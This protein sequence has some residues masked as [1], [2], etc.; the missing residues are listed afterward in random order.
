MVTRLLQALCRSVSRRNHGRQRRTAALRKRSFR[1]LSCEHLEDRRILNA[2]SLLAPGRVSLDLHGDVLV[3]GWT[4]SEDFPAQNAYDTTHNGGSDFVVTKITGLASAVLEAGPDATVEEGTVFEIG[5]TLVDLSG[6]SWT[7]WADFGDESGL[8]RVRLQDDGTFQVGH[9]FEDNGQYTVTVTAATDGDHVYAD[10]DPSGTL[11]DRYP[12]RVTVTDDD[13]GVTSGS[14]TV[15]VVNVVPALVAVWAP[16]LVDLREEFE[17]VGYFTDPSPTDV[18]TCEVTW[19]DG[20]VETVEFPA[21]TRQFAFPHRYASGTWRGSDTEAYPITVTLTDDDGGLA[22]DSLEVAVRGPDIVGNHPLAHPPGWDFLD[23]EGDIVRPVF[24]GPD[25]Y[26]ELYFDDDH[27]LVSIELHETALT[28][29]LAFHVKQTD[30]GDGR[31]DVGQITSDS[32][33]G[34]LRLGDVNLVGLGLNASAAIERV[35]LGNVA[36]DVQLAVQADVAD[37]LSL[38]ADAIGTNVTLDFGGKLRSLDVSS[39]AGGE[40]HVADAETIDVRA[41]DFG[42]D[43]WIDPALNPAGGFRSITVVGGD[44]RGSIDVPGHG[45]TITVRAQSGRG[46]SVVTPATFLI[47]GGLGGISTFGGDI[48]ADLIVMGD[49]GSLVARRDASGQGGN[50]SGSYTVLAGP[51]GANEAG[52]L[53]RLEAPGGS[54]AV[55]TIDVAGSAEIIAK[56]LSSPTDRQGAGA[57]VISDHLHV[58]GR[59]EILAEGGSIRAGDVEAGS[60]LVLTALASTTQAD[61]GNIE[62]ALAVLGGQ[63]HQLNA[64][65][66]DIYLTRLQVA[67]GGLDLAATEARSGS[68][69]RGGNIRI[70]GPDAAIQGATEMEARGGDIELGGQLTIHGDVTKMYA[71]GGRNGTG[72]WLRGGSGALSPA[73]VVDGVMQS[74]DIDELWLDL[75][76][77]SLVAARVRQDSVSRTPVTGQHGTIHVDDRSQGIVRGANGS[78]PL[79]SDDDGT[80]HVF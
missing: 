75:D 5:G 57:V 76:L 14:S 45:G 15:E 13:G 77:Q 62:L 43:L 53:G 24:T 60:D 51:P 56:A 64:W 66:G 11:R 79:S 63:L 69:Y 49:V 4:T 71:G 8:E 30:G 9:V 2:G 52:D 38:T 1:Y 47:G 10:D 50:I 59:L 74:L 33:L 67:E 44:Y 72:G 65:G 70:D 36:D 54:I 26:A 27:R 32:P 6:R 55:T 73:L 61:S 46:G 12:I 42:A 39:W 80:V 22:R 16:T 3:G 23:V 20:Q 19:G 7:L 31:I 29:G 34:K 78:I 37:S 18:H 58:G 40:I 48:A 17:L 68:A 35:W 28:S 21:G 25:G 41:G